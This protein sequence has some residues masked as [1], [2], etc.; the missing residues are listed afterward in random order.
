MQSRCYCIMYDMNKKVAT[1]IITC[2]VLSNG[3]VLFLF[4]MSSQMK[5][6]HNSFLRLFPSHLALDGNSFNIKYNSYYIAGGTAHHIYLGNYTS[7]LNMLIL[8][9]ALTDSQHVK[10]NVRGIMDQKFWSARVRVD[11]PHFYV[12]DGAVPRIYK[13]NVRNWQADR[14]MHDA[15]YFLDFEPIGQSSFAIKSLSAK[16]GE[17]VLGKITIEMPHYTFIPGLLQRQID[18]VFCTD[19]MMHYDKELARLIYLYRYRNQY[20]VLDTNLNLAY[21]GNT[22]DTISKAK[23]KVATIKTSNSTTLAAPP[24]MVNKYSAVSKNWLFVNSHLL[25]RN[26]HPKALDK[27]DVIDVYDLINSKYQFSFYIFNYGGE[28]KLNEFKVFGNRLFALFDHHIQVY[29]LNPQY[30]P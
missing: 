6:R 2:F 1:W 8:N 16:T 20:I 28:E 17:S 30:L 25:A 24:L 14:F 4:A 22:I 12:H 21:R 29:A 26:E 10:L 5:D 11:S 3:I 18:G 7:P 19:G 13:G 15:E 9:T 23:I 27:A